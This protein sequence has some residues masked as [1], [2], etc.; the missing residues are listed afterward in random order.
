MSMPAPGHEPA[1]VSHLVAVPDL[2]DVL[3]G[4][5]PAFD[6]DPTPP[7]DADQADR[8]LRRLRILA[9]Q[10]DADVELANT[11]RARIDLWLSVQKA[12]RAATTAWLEASL[13]MHMENHLRVGGEKA[14]R[15][16][17]LPNGDL[18]ARKQQPEYEYEDQDAFITWAERTG[19]EHLLRYKDPEPDKNAVKAAFPLTPAELD[20]LRPGEPT[21]VLAEDRCACVTDTDDPDPTCTDCGGHGSILTTV[22]GLRVTKQA[23]KITVVPS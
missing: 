5:E 12:R 20:S 18:V 6:T 16:I 23:D 15:T 10:D 17:H 3:A 21:G 11:E 2:A 8:W 13:Q 19:R 9:E 22:P 14:A 7:L 4:D 1:A